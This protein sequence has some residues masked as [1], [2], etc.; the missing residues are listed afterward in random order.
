[1]S[2]TPSKTRKFPLTLHA[3]GQYCKKIRGKIYYFGKDKQEAHRRY[4]EQAACLHSGTT[5]AKV[6]ARD[7]SFFNLCNLYIDSQ[8]TRMAYVEVSE[9]H[10]VNQVAIIKKIVEYIK[11]EVSVSSITI[12]DL[13]NIKSSLIE[14]KASPHTINKFITILKAVFNWAIDN[15]V[16]EKCPKLRV[17]KKVPLTKEDRAVFTPNQIK[18]LLEKSSPQMKA[19]IML[20]LNCGFGC[21]DCGELRWSSL[22]L[23]KRRVCFPRSKTGVGRNLPLWPETIDAIKGLG[24]KSEYVFLTRCG[25]PWVRT[26]TKTKN[27]EPHMVSDNAVSKVFKK[28]MDSTGIEFPKGT[29][30]YTL[31]RTA[32]TF[33]AKSKDPF[34]V[35]ELLGHAS[36]AMASV[37]VQSVNEQT[38][39]AVNA[40]RKMIIQGS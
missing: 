22:D 34:A 38:D 32:A 37:Y 7:I 21:T 2:K 24:K 3:T 36:L 35:K 4:L 30:F 39:K 18:T 5:T 8:K 11:P 17:L 19:M 1:M 29:G 12:L 23:D 14:K 33:L 31:R 16:I 13:Q 28:L 26:I 9:K 25:H 27:G 20:G 10:F 40:N 15:E 6:V